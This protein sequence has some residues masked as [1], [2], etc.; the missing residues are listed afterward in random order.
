MVDHLKNR[1]VF[2][3]EETYE[4]LE[5]FSCFKKG[6]RFRLISGIEGQTT[7][8]Y[9]FTNGWTTVCREKVKSPEYFG[10]ETKKLKKEV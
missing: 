4:L 10:I 1:I 9:H 5:D 8:G 6:D 7:P 2:L 3:S